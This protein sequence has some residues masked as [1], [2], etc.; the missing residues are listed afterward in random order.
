MPTLQQT[1]A[2]QFLARLAESG[3]LDADRI[4]QLSALLASDKKPKADDFVK[5]FAQPAGGDI[6]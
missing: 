2:E 1:I 4:K 5:L 3:A 6:K